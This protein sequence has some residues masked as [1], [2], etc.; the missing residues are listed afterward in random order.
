MT[1]QYFFETL[2]TDRLK[3][4]G[5][6]VDSLFTNDITPCRVSVTLELDRK[7]QIEIT[8]Y[9]LETLEKLCAVFK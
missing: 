2:E 4:I 3:V 7:E 6:E 1:T 5:Y 8:V 9:S